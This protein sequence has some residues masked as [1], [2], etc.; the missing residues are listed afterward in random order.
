MISVDYPLEFTFASDGIGHVSV[1]ATGL[2]DAVAKFDE[3]V[4]NPAGGPR[5][6]EPR[7]SMVGDPGEYAA[8]HGVQ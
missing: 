2:H 3:K 8:R 5:V 1:I 6:F 4:G 7:L